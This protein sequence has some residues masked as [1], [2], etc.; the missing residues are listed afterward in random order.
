MLE[1]SFFDEL[2][3]V[4]D[5]GG[6][7]D[8]FWCQHL[9]KPV[10]VSHTSLLFSYNSIAPLHPKLYTPVLLQQQAAGRVGGR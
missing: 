1:N 8:S 9:E 4:E 7:G 5:C 3:M 10:L 2:I 6:S